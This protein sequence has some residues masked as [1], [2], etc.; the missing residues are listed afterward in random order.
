MKHVDTTPPVFTLSSASLLNPEP[1]RRLIVLVPSL[2]LDLG[3]MTRKVWDL[4]DTMKLSILFL[5]LY[6]DP[7]QESSFRRELATMSAMVSDSRMSAEVELLQGS[8]WVNTVRSHYRTGDLV[9]C[10][11]GVGSGLSHKSLSQ[12]LQ[13]QLNVPLY[14]LSGLV[15]PAKAERPKWLQRIAAWIGSIAILLGFFAIQAGLSSNI[16][17]MS[18]SIVLEIVAIGVWNSLF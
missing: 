9:V 13:T 14:I 10:P 7:S 2:E 1:A 17:L 15:T 6:R 16:V 4:A 5:G 11:A 3:A 12:T 18:L 8:D